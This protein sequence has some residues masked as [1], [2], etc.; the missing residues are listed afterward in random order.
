MTPPPTPGTSPAEDVA[1]AAASP[2]ARTA[3]SSAVPGPP[4]APGGPAPEAEAWAAPSAPGGPFGGPEWPLRLL[5]CVL[6]LAVT[7]PAGWFS[8]SLGR[9]LLPVFAIAG[10]VA[11]AGPMTA[12][13]V[14]RDS[15]LRAQIPRHR[16][17]LFVV[18]CVVLA[19]LIPPPGWLAACDTALLLCYLL[20]LDAVVG[21][22]S[23]LRLL[24][25]PL[26]LVAF[27]G[28]SALVLAAALLPVGTAGPW[29]RLLAALAIAA[30]TASVA[31]ALWLR[32]STAHR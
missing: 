31:A 20:S 21:G 1:S 2:A 28:S 8:G 7:D 13:P 18:G 23:A 22:P 32:Q 12:R 24:R 9:L 19:A 30:S 5:G 4:V 14:V 16:N 29:A 17:T 6:A 15:R 26:V 11:A 25:R 3:N 10:A 27:F